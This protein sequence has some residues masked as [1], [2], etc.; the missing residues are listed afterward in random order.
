MKY[1]ITKSKVL[2][3]KLW[4]DIKNWW[5]EDMKLYQIIIGLILYLVVVSFLN[6]PSEA[7]MFKIQDDWDRE[8]RALLLENQLP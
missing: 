5:R 2:R 6:I 7:E 8:N 4:A 1:P 3:A